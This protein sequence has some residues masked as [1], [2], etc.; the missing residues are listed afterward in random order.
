MTIAIGMT[1]A[2]RPRATVA[3]SIASL[4]AAGFRQRVLLF[5]D[6]DPGTIEDDSLEMRVNQP[7][8]GGLK[9]FCHA[10]AALAET[11]SPWLLLLEDDTTWAAGSAK[12]LREDLARIDPESVGYLSLYMHSSVARGIERGRRLNAGWHECRLGWKSCGSQAYLFPL[13]SARALLA[14]PQ[15]QDYRDNW[16]KNRNRDNVA[17]KCLQDMGLRRLFRVPALVDHALGAG[18]SSLRT[19]PPRNGRYFTGRA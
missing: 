1:T 17:S 16:A 3:A 13:Q 11:G 5:A 19:K 8:L 7:P 12:A 2:P 15:F 6:G 18:N 4:R 14:D 10:L 9:N